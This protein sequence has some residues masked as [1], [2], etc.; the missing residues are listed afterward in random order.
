[1]NIKDLQ[2]KNEGELHKLLATERA[3]LRDLRFQVSSEQHK[4][5]HDIR[6]IR[7]SIAR[8]MTLLHKGYTVAKQVTNKI[9]PSLES[10]NESK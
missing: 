4:Q 7:K 1:M 9:A 6:V 3:K 2:N 10:K 5:V 8:I